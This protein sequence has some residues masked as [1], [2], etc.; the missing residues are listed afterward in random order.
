MNGMI[1]IPPLEIPFDRD[2]LKYEVFN[3]IQ[4]DQDN[5]DVISNSYLNFDATQAVALE[6]NTQ[7]A[8]I[9]SNMM[10]CAQTLN[11]ANLK[12]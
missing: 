9:L 8:K 3:S 2:R 7:Q 5:Y 6:I 12:C 11:F 10:A 4:L 1:Q